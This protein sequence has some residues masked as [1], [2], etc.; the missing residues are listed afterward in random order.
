[1]EAIYSIP[2]TDF[3]KEISEQVYRIIRYLVNIICM[4]CY[5]YYLFI[6]VLILDMIYKLDF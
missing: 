5:F 3:I 4:E 1:M 6:T 2:V